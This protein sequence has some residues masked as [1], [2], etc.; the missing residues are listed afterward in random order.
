MLARRLASHR[1]LTFPR[2]RCR[3]WSTYYDSQSGLHVPLHQPDQVSVYVLASTTATAD[4]EARPIQGLQGLSIPGPVNAALLAGW[5]VAKEAADFALCLDYDPSSLVLLQEGEEISKHHGNLI[6]RIE[7]TADTDAL[8]QAMASLLTKDGQRAGK[9]A[10][11][12]GVEDDP[13]D[14][15]LKASHVATLLDAITTRLPET[16]AAGVD[17]LWIY[18]SHEDTDASL[19]LCEELN[20]LDVPGPI[21]KSRM[22]VDLS[23]AT[24]PEAREEMATEC[25]T[26]GINKLVVVEDQISWLA[27]L[28][29]EQGKTCRVA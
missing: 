2:G 19:A 11:T 7:S 28:I 17:Y 15:I 16:T 27:G 8:C 4:M 22:I 24:L 13:E 10:L 26:M 25:L 12:V 6:W 21:L 14:P 3:H 20:Y 1:T 5:T 9:V 29:R 23:W 18:P